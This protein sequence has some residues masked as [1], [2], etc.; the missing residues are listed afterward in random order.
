MQQTVQG[1]VS[2]LLRRFSNSIAAAMNTL[3]ALPP[4]LVVNNRWGRF[5]LLAYVLNPFERG[6]PMQIS[7]HV[8]RLVPL[9]LALFHLPNFLNLSPRE[10]EVCLHS[11]PDL[12]I[13]KSRCK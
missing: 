8:E 10:R 9:S 7:L 13:S 4:S 2:V 6:L 12:R 5:H 1:D 11:W 3:S